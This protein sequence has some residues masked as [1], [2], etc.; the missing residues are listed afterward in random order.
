[1]QNVQDSL[2]PLKMMIK[3]SSS[4]DWLKWSEYGSLGLSAIGSLVAGLSG[5]IL[6]AAAPLTVA[7][8]LNLLSRQRFEDKTRQYLT[9]EIADIHGVIESFYQH[10]P[11]HESE[12]IGGSF[13]LDE[14]FESLELSPITEAITDLQSRLRKLNETVLRE[15]DLETLNFRFFRIDES[16]TELKVMTQDLSAINSSNHVNNLA[17]FEITSWQTK[18]AEL[19]K[20]VRDLEHQNK[21]IIKPYLKG[22]TKRLKQLSTDPESLSS[23]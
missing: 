11:H 12:D 2:L 1:M 7:L 17:P 15:D 16:I 14:H 9:S 19:E 3:S 10:H 8:S 5:Q 22:L 20:Q 13:P 21:H 23:N 18:I 4:E 6:Y